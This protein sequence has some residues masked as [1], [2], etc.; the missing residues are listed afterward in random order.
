MVSR[1]WVKPMRIKS[2]KPLRYYPSS[3]ER[4]FRSDNSGDDSRVL[5]N[6]CSLKPMLSIFY[7]PQ[8]STDYCSSN[9]YLDRR[10]KI[11]LQLKYLSVQAEFFYS[12]Y[13]KM[14]RK[15][16]KAHNPHTIEL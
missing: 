1:V 14:Y 16:S 11:D 13:F 9:P 4:L 3:M 2:G 10:W 12:N 7:M 15:N 8:I 5:Q 6:Q